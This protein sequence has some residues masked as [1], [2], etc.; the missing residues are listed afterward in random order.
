MSQDLFADFDAF[1]RGTQ[2]FKKVWERIEAFVS[3]AV[4]RGLRKRLVRGHKTADDLSAHDEIVQTVAVKLQELRNKP[5]C[6]FDPAKSRNGE[7]GMWA[8][9]GK[10]CDHEVGTYCRTWRGADRKTKVYAF[11]EPELN[12]IVC[13]GTNSRTPAT[14]SQLETAELLAILNDCLGRLPP[15]HREAIDL[16]FFQQL[17]DREA[18]R[19]IGTAPSTITKRVHAAIVHVRK[20]L[21]ESQQRLWGSGFHARH[22]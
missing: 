18:A 22:R 5:T 1:L 17:T 21:S 2:G 8:W 12:D 3:A 16:R 20:L 10:I 7:R 11:S 14:I 13:R 9:L 15:A 6:W 4:L 19:K